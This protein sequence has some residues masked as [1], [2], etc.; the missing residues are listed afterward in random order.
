MH[1]VT[2]RTECKKVVSFR[3]PIYV[4]L[5]ISLIAL[6][7]GSSLGAG[8]TRITFEP[9]KTSAQVEGRLAE[10]GAAVYFSLVARTGQHMRVRITPVTKGLITAGVVIFPSGRQDGG[11]GGLIFDYDLTETGEYLIRVTRRQNK[12]AGLFRLEVQL[13]SA[14]KRSSD[15]AHV[16]A[17]LSGTKSVAA[18]IAVLEEGM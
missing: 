10:S 2:P 3:V 14:K 18:I 9:G 5:V 16:F 1:R 17:W 6:V 15:A 11:P 12:V 4:A 13:L 8:A 7:Q